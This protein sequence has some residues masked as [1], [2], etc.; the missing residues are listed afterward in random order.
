MDNKF[1][2]GDIVNLKKVFCNGSIMYPTGLKERDETSPY[3]VLH[4]F[5]EDINVVIISGPHDEYDS[6]FWGVYHDNNVWLVDE[7]HMVHVE[8]T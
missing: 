6:R 4:N 5:S 7:V 2:K 1:K 3:R 8:R